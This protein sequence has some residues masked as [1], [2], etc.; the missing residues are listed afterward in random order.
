[1]S[2][3]FRGNIDEEGVN[4]D[5]VLDTFFA[6]TGWG[7]LLAV[8]AP[9][10]SLRKYTEGEVEATLYRVLESGDWQQENSSDWHNKG[11]SNDIFFLFKVYELWNS[12]R[13]NGLKSPLHVHAVLDDN[14]INFH[15]SNNKIEVLCEFFPE[16][17]VTMLYHQYDFLEQYYP[18]DA[19][20]WYKQYPHVAITD[21]QQYLDL[22]NIDTSKVEQFFGW[23]MVCDAVE[24]KDAVWGKLKPK[25]RDWKRIDLDKYQNNELYR[26]SPFLTVSDNY[27]RVAMREENKSL[28]SLI[29][30]SAGKV[31]FCGKTYQL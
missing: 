11:S 2:E 24:N 29:Q 28:K 25:H 23:G 7:N 5:E 27:H 31:K 17:E 19:V 30:T 9:V 6:H 12:I 1:M 8:T 26:N 13:R 10:E 16:A 14:W 21:K 18:D 3:N 15:P 4:T 20:L 22:Y